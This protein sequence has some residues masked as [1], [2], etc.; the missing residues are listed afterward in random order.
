MRKMEKFIIEV[1]DFKHNSLTN[2]QVTR[3]KI[4]SKYRDDLYHAVFKLT[5]ITEVCNA[6]I[7]F[8]GLAS[9]KRK[10]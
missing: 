3:L 1:G 6:P 10:P 9:T 4:N 2:V 7:H 8:N 5:E